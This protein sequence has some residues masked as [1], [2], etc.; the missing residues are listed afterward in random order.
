[1]YYDIVCTISWEMEIEIKCFYDNKNSKYVVRQYGSYLLMELESDKNITLVR[2]DRVIWTSGIPVIVY[3]LF[4][5][6][7]VRQESYVQKG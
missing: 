7:T 2:E 1:M 3:Y 4:R 5:F 6:V